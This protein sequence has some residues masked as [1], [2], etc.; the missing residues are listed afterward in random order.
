MSQIALQGPEAITA[1]RVHDVADRITTG[2]LA[3]SVLVA[4]EEGAHRAPLGAFCGLAALTDASRREIC[5]HLHAVRRIVE[6]DD[7]VTQAMDD[8][9]MDMV[10]DRAWRPNPLLPLQE[11]VDAPPGLRNS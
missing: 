10:R 11:V 4:C 2:L 8:W 9:I 6:F 1:E 7:Q 3:V 5:E